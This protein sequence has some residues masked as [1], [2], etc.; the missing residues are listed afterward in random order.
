MLDIF[1]IVT[2]LSIILIVYFKP[3]KKIND[4]LYE[5]KDIK[6]QGIKFRIKKIDVFNHMTGSSVLRKEYDIYQVGGDKEPEINASY[7]KKMKA[8]YR[9]IILG[10]VVVPF[11]TRKKEDKGLHVDEL[12][13]NWQLASELYDSIVDF[14]Y[15]KKKV[16]FLNLLNR[17]WLR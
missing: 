17:G 2:V 6:I 8:H 11:I 12:F 4:V 13:N 1:I 15:N 16:M 7:E 9:D 3:S 5:L 10:G 14:T